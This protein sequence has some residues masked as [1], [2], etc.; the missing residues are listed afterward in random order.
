MSRD[1]HLQG[2]RLEY[3]SLSEEFCMNGVSVRL[4][5]GMED[6]KDG[7]ERRVGLPGEPLLE[8]GSA[9]GEGS[10]RGERRGKGRKGEKR[11][12]QCAGLI[13]KWGYLVQT[14]ITVSYR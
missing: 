6:R 3:P 13:K 8:G 11:R 4:S 7:V 10:W 5:R 14:A 9:S 1:K 12:E 2:C